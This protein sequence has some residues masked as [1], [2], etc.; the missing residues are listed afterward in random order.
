MLNYSWTFWLQ[1]FPERQ[2]K[3]KATTQSQEFL[4]SIR[5]YYSNTITDGEKQDAMNLWAHLTAEC[6]LPL[7]AAP[8]PPC[9]PLIKYTIKGRLIPTRLCQN[10]VIIYTHT[11][12]WKYLESDGSSAVPIHHSLLSDTLWTTLKWRQ[13]KSLMFTSA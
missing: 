12:S 3:W 10:Y 1:V 9:D 13:P 8:Y 4:K 7:H 11:L 6:T 5:R 2:G